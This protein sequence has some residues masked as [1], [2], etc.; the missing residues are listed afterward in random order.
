[1]RSRKTAAAGTTRADL[2]CAIV[3]LTA[4]IGV[5]APALFLGKVLLPADIVILMPPW[6]ASAHDRFPDHRF[7]QNQLHGPIFEYYSWR[8]YARERMR[9]GEVPLWNPYE[10]CGNVLL[11][12]SQ[13][14]VLYPPNFLLYLFSLPTG[15][16]MVTALHTFLTGLFMYGLLRAL[17]LRPVAALTGGLAWM[18][19]GLQIVWT[20]FQT[21]TAALCWLP[22]ALW[23]WERYRDSGD[24]RWAVLGSSGANCLA[25]LAGHLQFAFY[26][27]LAFAVYA[28][29]RTPRPGSVGLMIAALGLGGLLSMATNLPVLEMGRMNFRAA[30]TDYAS[31]ISLRL[32]P[33][34]LFMLVQP[35][36]FGNPRDYVGFDAN[37]A[38]TE[39]NNYWGQYDFIEYTGYMGVPALILALGAGTWWVFRCS[40]VQVFRR[41]GEG[42]T[43]P[44]TPNPEP[45]T[46]AI[47][48]WLVILLVGLLLALGTPL[49]AVLFYGVPGY[50]Q[51]NA[52]ARALCLFSF[53][54]AGLA[55]YGVELLLA[56]VAEP[57]RRRRAVVFAI[58]AAVVI[59]AGLVAFPGMGLVWQRL[60]TDQWFGYELRGLRMLLLFGAVT[61]GLMWLTVRRS[62]L[63]ISCLLPVAVAA[64]LLAWSTGFNPMTEPAMLGYPTA[65]TDYLQRA[66][67]NRAVSLETPGKGIKSFIVPNYNVVPHLR[68]VQGADSLHTWRYHHLLERI[69]KQMD[70]AWGGFSDPNTVHVPAV[71]HQFFN[72]LNVRYISTQMALDERLFNRADDAEMTIYENPRAA[73]PAWMVG[74]AVEAHGLDAISALL[75]APDFDGRKTAV[76]EQPVSELVSGAAVGSPVTITAF[77]PHREEAD[78]DARAPGLV[79]FSESAFPGWRARVDGRQQ[80]VLTADYVLRSVYVPAGRHHITLSYEPASYRVGLYLSAVA[81][82]LFAALLLSGRRTKRP[83]D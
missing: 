16:N 26:V 74:G 50:R 39:G 34:Q 13:S 63:W 15:I 36:L 14:A 60:F 37:G 56:D 45:Q 46:P 17:G 48:F 6:A 82:G 43:E 65:T 54:V 24:W 77:S 44:R 68:E 73:G 61:C 59:L 35:N 79:V 28:V 29:V 4:T 71:S 80:P 75:G 66:G 18:F 58:A 51:F 72:L 67:I 7:A 62:S 57:V 78:V 22:G 83:P 9:A 70:A 76:V 38:P 42:E 11:A 69:V 40:G 64:D 23:A 19:C 47:G 52:T 3:L 5:Y 53:G 32:P 10:L 27:C 2:L 20:E 33:K 8:H 30:H 49:C 25:L 12:N 41:S 21:P 55:G 1:M 31:S 81:A